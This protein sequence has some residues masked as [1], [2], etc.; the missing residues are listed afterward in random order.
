MAIKKPLNLVKKIVTSLLFWLILI[1]IKKYKGPTRPIESENK[2]IENLDNL[3]NDC[4]LFLFDYL[5]PNILLEIIKPNI[6]FLSDQWISS[7]IEKLVIDKYGGEIKPH[8]IVIGNTTKY[9]PKDAK[10]KG[11]YFRS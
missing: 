3:F 6:Y 11:Q 4:Y 9:I 7:P 8:P 2:R 1:N 5:I 10:S